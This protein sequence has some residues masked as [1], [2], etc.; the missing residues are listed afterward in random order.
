MT[1]AHLGDL[2]DR[3]GEA[4]KAIE[5][6]QSAVAI[7]RNGLGAEHYMTGYY[8]DPL[9]PT[10]ISKPTS[11]RPPKK[12][13]GSRL[14]S[15]LNRCPRSISSSAP[16]SKRSARSCC[17]AD[18]L[19]R[20]NRSFAPHSRSIRH[21]RA[22]ISWRAARSAAS[23]GWVLIKREKS[24]EGEPMLIAAR[25]RLLASVGA[26]HPATREATDRLAEYYRSRHRDAEAM[27]VLADTTKR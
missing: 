23:L 1:E 8:L 18:P 27:Q 16:S 2:Y 17:G 7:A 14:P 11:C 13:R 9:L 15:T 3:R 4:A 12:P 25:A 6:T 22:R 10:A 5:A 26:R 21:S 20:P 19:P 24:G